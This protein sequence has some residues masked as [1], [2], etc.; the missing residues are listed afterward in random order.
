M[1]ITDEIRSLTQAVHPADWTD[2]D[3]K[4][5]DTARVLAADAVQKVGNGHPGTAMSLA[6]V[7]YTLFQ[8]VMR[9]DPTDPHWVGRDRFVLSCGHSSLTLYIQ[10]YL[11]GYGL[12]LADLEALRTWGSKTP[13]H[14]E[15]GH[16][17]GVEMTTGPL[18]QGL[19]SAVG[20]A[21]AA[22]RE[23]G[24]FDPDAATGA[25]PFDHH[26]Y[27]LA[28]D[29]D[30]EEGVTS[31]ASS[32]AGV[33]QLGNLIVFYDDNKISIEHDTAIALGEDVAKRYEAYGWHVQTVEGGENV[34]AILDAV[35][36]AKAVTDKPSLVVLRT[37]IGYPA[38]TKMNT[39]DVH[40]AALGADEVA[41]VKTA[42]G[43]DP[44]KHF[45]VDPAVIE[46]TRAVVERGAAARTAWQ[47]EF[48]AWAGREP[49]RK[50][51]FDRLQSGEF[52]AGWTE[53][54]PT[55]EP[56]AKGPATRKASGSAL[57]ALGPV[58]PELW[59]G[60]ADLAGSNNTTIPGSDSFG[61]VSISTKDWNAQPYG[62]TLHFGVREHA[63]GS[64][65]NGIA[66]H[67]PTRPYG[68]TF[69]VFSDYMRP[70]VRLAAL[71]QT[72]AI[73]VW[74]HDSIG[75]GE[76]GPTHQ[77][78]EHLT[79]L[80]AIPN[81]AVIRPGDANETSFAWAAALENKTG[82]TAL[83]LTRQDV[84]VL[85]G[86]RERAAEGLAR[87]AYV[88]AEASSGTPEVVLLGTGSE[89]Q[90]A[91]AAR[92]VLEADGVPTRVV[93]VPVL[94]WFLEQ[95]QAYRDAVLPPAVRARV[96]VEAGLAMPWYRLLGDA[97]EAVSLEHFGASADHKTLF[98]EFGITAE[99]VVDA[100][101]RSLTRVK[102]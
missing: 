76:D 91:V 26:V 87:G 79:A 10:L 49:Q 45:D 27:V 16:T 84:P 52:P 22:R 6:P 102:G 37:I 68:G 57:A 94:D 4:A 47:A 69:L 60:S 43:F 39:G 33:Q 51:L 88:L 36:A 5:V 9:H 74:T 50:E 92:E 25:S 89:L 56:A 77:P 96:S 98:R 81:L 53:V 63:M 48:D 23:R 40:G 38:P 34:T 13:G 30:I 42:L 15:F 65:L 101:R 73:Y 100:A 62:R 75:L 3:T 67:G 58:L 97:G 64:I 19:A 66:L 95:D 46:H 82:P 80:R 24:L 90:L 86:T 32:L 31:E 11:S 78:V 7:A 59:G 44:A 41:A 2:L 12:E 61:P 1:S 54:L 18:G 83:A 85:E 28:S 8:R 20:M 70:A 99:A 55:Y 35:E 21:M 14:P 29:G 17:A 71:M 93:S 72:P